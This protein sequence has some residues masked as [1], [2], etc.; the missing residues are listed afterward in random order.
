MPR[1]SSVFTLVRTFNNY[2]DRSQLNHTL[3]CLLI[4]SPMSNHEVV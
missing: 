1:F 4:D 3:D 2:D